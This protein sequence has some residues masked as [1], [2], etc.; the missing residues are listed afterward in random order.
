MGSWRELH[1][2]WVMRAVDPPAGTALPEWVP[3][4]VPGCVHSD[5]L[6]AGLIPDPYLDQNEQRLDWIGRC[7][8]EYRTTFDW[9]GASPAGAGHREMTDLVCS[10]LDT[11][12]AITLNGVAI[13]RTANMHRGYRFDVAEALRSGQNTLVIRFGSAYRYAAELRDRLGDR[14]CSYPQPF[15]FIRKMASNFGWDWG[16][17]VVTAGIWQNIGLHH[18]HRARLA[19]VRPLVSL[20]QGAGLVTLKVA[21]ERASAEPLHL[22]ASVGQHETVTQVGAGVTEATVTVTVPE[23]RLWWPHGHGEPHRYPAAVT[24][25]TAAGQTLDTWQRRI[26][27]R[28]VSLD[29]APDDAGSR[30]TIVVN[31]QPVFV[32]GVNWIPDD[33]LVSRIDAARYAERLRQARDAN[34]NYVRVWGGGIYESDDFY[35]ACDELGL[36]AGQDFLFACAAYPEEEPLRGE[37]A[38]EAAYQVGRLAHHPSLVLWT[39][40]NENIWGYYDWGWPD[41]LAG[42]TWGAGYYFDL[43]PSIVADLDPTRPYWPGSPYSGSRSVHPNDPARG[44][45]HLW[46]IWNREDY[47]RYRDYRPRFVGEF[48]Y[49]A[50]A[51]YATLRAAISEGPLTASSPGVLARQKAGDGMAKLARGLELRFGLAGEDQD[52]LFLTQVVQARAFC[53]GIEHFRSLWPYCTG[54]ILWQLNDDWPSISWSL[55]DSGG[56]RKPAWYA[57]RRSYAPR[58]LTIQ[59]EDTGL[60][61]VAVNETADLW[62]GTAEVIRHGLDGTNLAAELIPVAVPAASAVRVP[63]P[64]AITRPGDPAAEVVRA[65]VAGSPDGHGAGVT[66][67]A[68]WFFAEDKQIRY[69]AARFDVTT[70]GAKLTV[71]ARTILRDLCVLADRLDRGRCADHAAAGGVAHVHGDRG[72]RPR[73][74]RPAAGAAVRQ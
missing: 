50:P 65:R 63:L 38:A 47:V 4:S 18:W 3:A 13:G 52:W 41:Q 34:A 19:S 29:T 46:E 66:D 59:P 8:W 25:T 67:T 30:Y 43:L 5:L 53:V 31:G 10:G 42:R 33:G 17:S 56:R 12:A 6:T 48:G 54:A 21:I 57:V 26:G 74:E 58:L 9:A 36:M 64:A 72:G 35:D 37:V 73:P 55:V 51:T 49:Q 61:L 15:N 44:S 28:T 7:D 14:P 27:F 70:E 60:D 39:G 68:W 22:V 20:D 32:R 2:G 23:P 71:T 24:L 16:P 11:V 69:P 45:T 1:S 62:S 40:N